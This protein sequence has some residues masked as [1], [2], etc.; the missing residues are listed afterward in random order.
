MKKQSR[1][2]EVLMALAMVGLVGCGGGGGGG[3]STPTGT[4]STDTTPPVVTLAGEKSITIEQFAT[5][6]K[7]LGATAND[8]TD[9]NVSVNI[10]GDVGDQPNVYTITYEAYDNS[11]NRGTTDR[12]VTV[13]APPEDANRTKIDALAL[14][15]NGANALYEGD[16]E[17]RLIQIIAL[18]NQIHNASRT[19]VE[20]VLV[21]S[22]Q[23]SKIND[24]NSMYTGIETARTDADIARIRDSVQADEVLVYQLLL[25]AEFVCG[26]GYIN[27]DFQSELA[28]SIVGIN[29]PTENTA[30]E[31]GHNMGNTHSHMQDGEGYVG[32][33]P[34]STG[35]FVEG[36]FGTVMTYA[37]SYP[38]TMDYKLVYSNPDLEC[39]GQPCGIEA[40]E[41]GEADASRTIRE[42]KT[43]TSEIR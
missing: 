25:E 16:I 38:D 41:V 12:Y 32:R 33:H 2:L 35:H 24:A 19:G 6:Y 22:E 15:T 30:H 3:S 18:T 31:I 37:F 27:N 13:T 21:H 8:E 40:G 5:S 4:T 36:S 9:G 42:T 11:G 23:T 14:Y 17:T 10:I 28:T 7:E 43:A 20:I 1:K 34:Y 29:C 39:N 26:L